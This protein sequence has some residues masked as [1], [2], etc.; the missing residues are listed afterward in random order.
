M[1]W[2]A[3]LVA[4]PVL[5]LLLLRPVGPGRFPSRPDPARDYDEALRRVAAAGARDGAG[6]SPEGRT[7]L[8]THGRRTARAVVLLHG[9]TNC[10]EQFRLLGERLHERGANVYLPRMLGHGLTDRMDP[11]Q[12]RLDASWLCRATDEAVDIARGLGEEVVVAGLSVGGTMAAWAAQQRADVARAVAI[13]PLLGLAAA[14]GPL[15]RPAMNLLL[16]L[17]NLFVWWDIRV[18]ADLPGP[19]HVYP[20]FSTRAVAQTLRLAAGIEADARRA[21][22]AAGTM[23]LVTA[24]DDA[25]TDNGAADRLARRWRAHGARVVTRHFPARLGLQHD[26]VDPGQVGADP[27]LVYPVLLDLIAP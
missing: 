5:A 22:P 6:V 21:A 26:I 2:F 15:T 10:P 13:A 18:R 7:R 25:A 16:A 17:P 19:G 14:P 23:A 24:G 20:R 3:V 9:L 11:G 1:W 8:L 4:L 12:A 27:A